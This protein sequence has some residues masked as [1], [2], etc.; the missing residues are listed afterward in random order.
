MGV[1]HFEG[2]LDTV[3]M[4]LYCISLC[5]ERVKKGTD[6]I[7]GIVFLEGELRIGPNLKLLACL[8]SIGSRIVSYLLINLAKPRLILLQDLANLPN[9]T[10]LTLYR[11]H[12][13]PN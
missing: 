8:S 10:L 12:L 13:D 11:L 5:C 2:S 4:A 1:A 7:M 6:I 3:G 9:D